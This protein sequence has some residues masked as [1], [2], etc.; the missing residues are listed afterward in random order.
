MENILLDNYSFIF[1]AMS[2][3][4]KTIQGKKAAEAF[5]TAL[6]KVKRQFLN[7]IKR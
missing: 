6:Y 5:I 3:D 1:I 4:Y 7:F 2:Y